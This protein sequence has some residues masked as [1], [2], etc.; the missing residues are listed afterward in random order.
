LLLM[1]RSTTTRYY[2][3]EAYMASSAIVAKTPI[4]LLRNPKNLNCHALI[5]MSASIDEYIHISA[6]TITPHI[7]INHDHN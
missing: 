2:L 3:S 6:C 1:W 4:H 5:F 7:R